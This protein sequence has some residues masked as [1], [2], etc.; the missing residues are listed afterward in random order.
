M[1]EKQETLPCSPSPVQH[2]VVMAIVAESSY[3]SPE[4]DVL[5]FTNLLNVGV[6]EWCWIE[7]V[8]SRWER[9]PRWLRREDSGDLQEWEWGWPKAKPCGGYEGNVFLREPRYV[10]GKKKKWDEHGFILGLF[11][12]LQNP[13]HP[14]TLT[15]EV[16]YPLL[17]YYVLSPI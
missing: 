12:H 6:G 3:R 11:L 4:N 8:R 5:F 17:R 14:A 9:K 13:S 10:R 2:R 1:S 7:F 16:R 15:G